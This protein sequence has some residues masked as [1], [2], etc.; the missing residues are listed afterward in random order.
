MKSKRDAAATLIT[1]HQTLF[2]FF[3]ILRFFCIFAASFEAKDI[4]TIK[5]EMIWT[6]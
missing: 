6:R 3:A 1:I 2:T 4:Q 5:K